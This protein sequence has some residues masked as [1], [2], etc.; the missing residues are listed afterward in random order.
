MENKI[1]Q[2][3]LLS[4]SLLVS[5]SIEYIDRC[6]ESI[7]P[8]LNQIPSELIV[9]DTGGTDGSID[10]A[11]KYA[12]CV[13]QFSWCDDFAAARNAGLE[14][15][16]GEWFL[17]LDDDEWFDDVR[18]I[19]DFFQSGEY[20][21][22]NCASY[23]IRNY[24]DFQGKRWSEVRTIRLTKRT[25]ET[26]F[27]SKIHEYLSPTLAPEKR[28]EAYV[29]HYGYVYKDK[30]K[31]REHFK[32]NVDLI[33]QGLVE[34]PEDLRL[35]VQLAQ[36]YCA[37]NEYQASE[38]ICIKKIDEYIGGTARDNAYVG[39]MIYNVVNMELAKRDMHQAYEYVVK[40]TELQWLNAVT[41]MCLMYF[42]TLLCEELDKTNEIFVSAKLFF[43]IHDEVNKNIEAYCNEIILSQD[44]IIQNDARWTVLQGLLRASM[45]EKNYDCVHACVSEI[46]S[47]DRKIGNKET[48]RTLL[49]WCKVEK[50]IQSRTGIIEKIVTTT[51]DQKLLIM[52]LDE[53]E[54]DELINVLCSNIVDKRDNQEFLAQFLAVKEI[55]AGKDD[56]TIKELVKTAFC[57]SNP[58][59]LCSGFWSALELI[60]IDYNEF[61]SEHEMEDW[62]YKTNAFIKGAK[63]EKIEAVYHAL[64]QADVTCN[65]LC[66]VN[67]TCLD[68][69]L[70]N[71]V[72][73]G[74]LDDWN[75]LMMDYVQLVQAFYGQY[76]T[77]GVE[78]GELSFL[79]PKAYRFAL[80]MIEAETNTDNIV[81]YAKRIRDAAQVYPDMADACKKIIEKISNRRV[82][83]SVSNEFVDLANSVKEKVNEF[84]EAGQYQQAMEVIIEL[85]KMLPNDE[86]VCTLERRICEVMRNDI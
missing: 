86:E 41:L 45:K 40:Y 13:V 25:R 2:T 14:K 60:K 23:K 62:F 26:K 21:K 4:V 64:C 15:S 27:V 34:H 12:D 61:L 53:D 58:Y 82:L 33:K 3:K 55:N 73:E 10:I 67:I 77:P 6:M 49:Q 69:L 47:S 9:V 38:D 22:Y 43:A 1:E 52:L 36:E 72:A 79:L 37:I 48:I 51:E 28:F 44:E 5:N 54:S 71:N 57:C 39:W 81:E 24:V 16:N 20:K 84:V 31:E 63:R 83:G 32:R 56:E 42:K 75:R 17:F 18:E 70:R 8:L 7:V 66:Y 80:K 35:I 76:V 29:H 85:R 46:L 65:Q 68:Y 11:R 78:N 59:E 50:N 19:I 30:K 74:K